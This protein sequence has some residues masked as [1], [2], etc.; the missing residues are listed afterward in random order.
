VLSETADTTLRVW[1]VILPQLLSLAVRLGVAVLVESTTLETCTRLK[2]QYGLG[3][4]Q[5]GG[6]GSWW[7][8]ISY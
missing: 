4:L 7:K 3:V 1:S 6:S 8:F 2:G 5:G